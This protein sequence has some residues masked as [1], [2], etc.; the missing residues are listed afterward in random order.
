[1]EILH[2]KILGEGKPLLILHGYFGMGDNWKTHANKF[3]TDGFQV[4]LIDQRN[5]G[6]SFHSEEFSYEL[7]VDDLKKYIDHYG[8]TDLCLLGHSMG[9]K[10]AMLFA[11]RYP[12][13][14]NKLIVADISPKMYPP[15]HHDILKALNAVDFS[16]HTTRK[17]IEAKLSDLIPEL[18]VRQ[19]LLKSV[20]RKEKDVLDF[21][22]NLSSLTNNTEEVGRALPADTSFLGDTLFL[23]GEKSGYITLED[24]VLIKKHFPKASIAKVANAGHW[25]HAENPKDFYQKTVMFIQ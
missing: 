4:H 25:L 14:L 21:R 3:V 9:G 15:H 2:S 16:I 22:F 13:F 6:R 19:F 11:V 23:S 24:E 5:H 1:M 10:V 18:G 20:Y 17:L 7:L 8:L 12:S